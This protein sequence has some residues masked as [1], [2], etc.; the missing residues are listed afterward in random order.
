MSTQ[1]IE[2][3]CRPLLEKEV[4]PKAKKSTSLQRKMVCTQGDYYL[5]KSYY[6]VD[7]V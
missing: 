2:S 6:E 3:L 1:N 4:D 7:I 5:Y